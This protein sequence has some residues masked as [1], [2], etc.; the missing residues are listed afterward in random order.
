MCIKIDNEWESDQINGILSDM[1][2]NQMNDKKN[3]A[4]LMSIDIFGVRIDCINMDHAITLIENWTEKK[5]KHYI[6]TPNVEFVM[7][8]QQDA[9]FKKILNHSDLAIPDSS[10]FGWVIAQQNEKSRFK[11]LLGVPK[12]LIRQGDFP[13]VTGTDLMQQLC[14]LAAKKN[15][16]VGLLGG[17]DGVALKCAKR[18]KTLY[19]SLKISF[20]EDG[21]VVDE[22]GNAKYYPFKP[23]D[24]LFVAFGQGKQEKWIVKNKEKAPFKVAMGVGGAFDYISGNV[25][26]APVWMRELGLEWLFRI[27]I[28]PWRAK[29]F[30]SLIKFVSKVAM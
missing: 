29:R 14:R 13:V 9:A 2:L 11:K 28:Q 17:R 3:D 7:K 5:G 16:S 27:L 15:L 20:A 26:R 10:R 1:N 24:F 23:A 6:V 30:I 8:A 18:L 22:N 12:F 25:A 21:P 4:S 19:P